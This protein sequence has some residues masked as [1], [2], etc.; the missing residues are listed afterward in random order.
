[1]PAPAAQASRSCLRITAAIMSGKQVRRAGEGGHA[2]CGEPRRQPPV[3]GRGAL[4]GEGEQRHHLHAGGHEAPGLGQLP[5]LVEIGAQHQHRVLGSGDA[6]GAVADRP[7]D[8][9]AAAELDR[10]QHLDRIV[11]R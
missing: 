10:E 8:V 2:E 11:H 7:V 3:V 5:G 4:V 1:M 6:R 9:G